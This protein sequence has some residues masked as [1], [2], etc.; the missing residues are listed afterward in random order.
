MPDHL[1]PDDRP[2]SA[3]PMIITESDTHIVPAQ[4][5]VAFEIAR[6]MLVGYRRLFEQLFAAADERSPR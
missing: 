3:P 5:G 2:A 6:A 1:H 4:A